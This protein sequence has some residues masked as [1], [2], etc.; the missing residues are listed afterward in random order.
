MANKK[1]PTFTDEDLLAELEPGLLNK[2]HIHFITVDNGYKDEEVSDDELELPDNATEHQVEFQRSQKQ[3][4]NYFSRQFV[5][6]KLNVIWAVRTRKSDPM[7][8]NNDLRGLLIAGQER[9]AAGGAKVVFASYAQR[10]AHMDIMSPEFYRH[11]TV[12]RSGFHV[13]NVDEN[14]KKRT[15]KSKPKI[16]VTEDLRFT[17]PFVLAV[18]KA[19]NDN[20]EGGVIFDVVASSKEEELAA[21]DGLDTL[22]KEDSPLKGIVKYHGVKSNT[23]RRNI[24]KKAD[25]WFCPS[26]IFLFESKKLL[27]ALSASCFIVAPST[28]AMPELTGG[29]GVLYQWDTDA[30]IHVQTTYNV[31]LQTVLSAQRRFSD[32]EG[33]RIMLLQNAWVSTMENYDLRKAQWTQF[34]E[35]NGQQYHQE[36]NEMVTL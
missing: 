35:F 6:D 23:Q 11:T 33:P 2:N 24:V 27:E 10:N 31:L 1:L 4:L 29:F 36:Q 13:M 14:D 30:E 7:S 22:K 17:L 32:T 5:D 12:I 34:L 18:A 15:P 9:V 8:F 28:G 21:K 3:R 26:N 16:V 19:V 25:V 20:V